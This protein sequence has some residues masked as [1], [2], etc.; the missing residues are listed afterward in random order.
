MFLDYVFV[1]FFF[2]TSFAKALVEGSTTWLN[3]GNVSVTRPFSHAKNKNIALAYLVAN[4]PGFKNRHANGTAETP[5]GLEG[6]KVD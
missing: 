1:V 4:L 5:V 3:S 6:L 2:Y